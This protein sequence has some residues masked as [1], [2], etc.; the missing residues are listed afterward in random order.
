LKTS[1]YNYFINLYRIK[2][3]GIIGSYYKILRSLNSTTP[4]LL[5]LDNINKILVLAPHPDDDAVGCGGT[6][7]RLTEKGCYGETVFFTNGR[8]N[9]TDE[10][11]EIAEIRRSEAL[12]GSKKIGIK[13]SHFLNYCD[14]RLKQDN[15]VVD[16]VLSCLNDL[17]PDMVFTPFFI[18]NHPDNTKTAKILALAANQYNGDFLCCCYELWSTLTPNYIVDT[19][20][21][22]E[23]KIAAIKIHESQTKETDLVDLAKGLNR[24]RAIASGQPIQYAEAFFV[25]SKKDFIKMSKSL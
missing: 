12:R 1:I 24:Y 14:S 2:R 3:D 9:I 4:S 23:K 6:L 7:I 18:D 15:N 10:R 11:N 17:K 25:A 19:T 21:F 22:M 16:F 5:N 20:S 8:K 13:N